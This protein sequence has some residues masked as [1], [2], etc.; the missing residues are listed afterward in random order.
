MTRTRPAPRGEV[1][2]RPTTYSSQSGR[3]RPNQ[4]LLAFRR[5]SIPASRDVLR[6][7][8]IMTDLRVIAETSP[9]AAHAYKVLKRWY[10]LV[11]AVDMANRSR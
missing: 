1:V 2:E 11:I 3:P 7:A 4:Y 10:C 6:L 9:V 5:G 8:T